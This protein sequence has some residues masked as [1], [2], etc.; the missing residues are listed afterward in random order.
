MK[1]CDDA[2]REQ[3]EGKEKVYHSNLAKLVAQKDKEVSL[4]DQKVGLSLLTCCV[5][6]HGAG[7]V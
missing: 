2:F 4:A 1:T 5:V 3:L 6:C 7:A